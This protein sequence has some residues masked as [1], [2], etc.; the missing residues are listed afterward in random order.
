ML[1]APVMTARDWA[2]LILL[3]VL[4]GGSF[5]FA[6]VA[7][8]DLPPLTLAWARVAL[9]A[10]ALWAVVR[11]LA[12]AVPGD[13]RSWAVLFGMGLLNN[14]IPFSLIIWGQT[15]IESGLAAILNGATPLFAV[16]I[17]PFFIAEERLTAN[18]LIGIAVGIAGVGVMIGLDAL[19]G[20]GGSTLGQLAV[21]AGT[22]SYACAGVYARRLIRVPALVAAAGQVTGST[23]L[24]APLALMV[25]QPWTLALPGAATI[26]AVLG[27]GIVSTAMAYWLY[28][29]LLA[30]AGPTNL[31]LVTLLI[32]VSAV[33]LGV[34]LLG[35]RLEPKHA[36]GFALIAAGLAWIDGRLPRR[37][38]RSVFP[39]RPDRPGR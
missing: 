23:L 8:V 15:R 14:V 24:L 11:A 19:G 36:L 4:W 35:E 31:L 18:R 13:A 17:A 26:A 1:H 9:G 21:V 3:S 12:L 6:E 37:F 2:L 27:F 38:S 20:I 34:T 32:P 25:D 29:T 16:L 7:L 33:M 5:F 28:F 30:S 22:L 10:L 39:P